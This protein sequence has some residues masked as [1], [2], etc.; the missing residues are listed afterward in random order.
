ML[1]TEKGAT[2]TVSG[3]SSVRVCTGIN[4]DGT[5]AAGK[6]CSNWTAVEGEGLAGDLAS[7]WNA[8]SPVACGPTDAASAPRL[9]CFAAK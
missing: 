5:A 6:T 2:V 7:T 3:A 9:Y 4:A 1:R 8:T